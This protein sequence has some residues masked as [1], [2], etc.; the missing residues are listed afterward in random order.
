MEY[1]LNIG[2]GKLHEKDT[3]T[4]KWINIDKILEVN[5]DYL[6]DIIK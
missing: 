5:P 1:K 6:L 2:C 3:E 4:I